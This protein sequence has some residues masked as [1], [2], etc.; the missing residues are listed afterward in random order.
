[1][2]AREFLDSDITPSKLV[3]KC[4]GRT[5]FA[6][7]ELAEPYV[8]KW[9]KFRGTL[10]LCSPLKLIDA[11][12]TTVTMR[13]AESGRP[14]EVFCVFPDD[15]D[16]LRLAQEGDWLSVEGRIQSV[17]ADEIIFDTCRLLNSLTG[18]P[19]VPRPEAIPTESRVKIERVSA[20]PNK[21]GRPPK[22][23]WEDAIVAMFDRIFHGSFNPSTQAEIEAAMAT[24]IL[25]KHGDSPSE[26]SVRTRAAKIFKVHK[27]EG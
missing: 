20:S 11:V 4:K 10:L 8:G 12:V 26:A 27:K 19:V 6:S 7:A 9:V 15:K 14:L 22:S 13:V 5:D 21:G 18:E 17:A 3:R 24:W 25:E 16:R 1:M 2:A 23:Y